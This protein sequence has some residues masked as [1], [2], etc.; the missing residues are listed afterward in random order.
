[1]KVLL[2]HNS[3]G[4]PLDVLTLK[5]FRGSKRLCVVRTLRNY[6]ERTEE[7]RMSEQLLLSFVRPFKPISRDTLSR[8]TLSVMELAGVDITRY[9]GHSTRGASTSAACRLGVP[10]NLILRHA[11]WRSAD[12]FAKFYNKKL[13]ENTTEVGQALLRDAV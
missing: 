7:H 13:E 2:K 1:M 12:S 8:W 9:R 6:L 3:L 10:V 5:A 4:D 11:S